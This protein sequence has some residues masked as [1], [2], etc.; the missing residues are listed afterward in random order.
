MKSQI[1]FGAF[2]LLAAVAA[3]CQD[4]KPGH[5]PVAAAGVGAPLDEKFLANVDSRGVALNGG[6]DPVAFFTDNKPVKGDPSHRSVYRGAVYH[7]AS[8]E[9]KAKFDADPAKYEPQFG[10]FCAYAASINK[11]SPVDVKYFE[12]VNG[13]LLLQHNQQAWDLWHQA[14]AASLVD[15]DR[16]WPGLVERNGL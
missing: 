9:H 3:G 2:A 14:P 15:A 13:R 7:F 1:V 16:N 6:Y 12:I 4:A 5:A 11:V 8:A 10:G